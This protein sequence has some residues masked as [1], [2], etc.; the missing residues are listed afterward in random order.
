RRDLAFNVM[1][2]VL[3]WTD[4]LWKYVDDDFHKLYWKAHLFKARNMWLDSY[5]L[6]LEKKREY[7][8]RFYEPRR[9]CFMK[10]GLIQA[11]QDLLDGIYELVAVSL[12][13]GGGKTTLE[14][15]LHSGICGWFPT[16]YNLFYS[17]SGDITRMYYDG[18]YDILTNSEEYTWGEIFPDC[19]VTSTNAKLE[20]ININK[21]KPFPNVQCTSI[22]AKNA[23][24]VRASKF[25]LC[26]DMVGGIEEALN[27]AM[28]ETIWNK[29]S[30]DARQ[31]KIAGCQEL[32]L[33]TRWSC[34][35]PVG[36][37][38]NAYGDNPKY[39]FIAIP[40]IDPETGES[41]FMFD[42]NPFTVEFF[43]D[44]EKIMDEVTYRCLYK[45]DPIEREGLLIPEDKLRRYMQLPQR[46]PDEIIGQCDTKGKGTDYFVLPVLYRYG[47]DYYCEDAICSNDTDYEIQYERSASILVNHKVQS[48]DFER[49]AGGDRVA[50]EVD[51]RVKEKG[52]ICNI[53][54][55]PTETN[56]EAKIFQCSNWIMQHILF[57]DKSQYSNKSDYAELIRELC[58]YSATG[59]NKHDDVPDCL[60]T[61][62]I[63]VTGAAKASVV[64]LTN[65]PFWRR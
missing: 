52:W 19:K 33:M 29:Y 30:V 27:P 5:L 17:H 6:Y 18:M 49:N 60:A 64:T 53:T 22:G 57:K 40:D 21:Y 42:I 55:T 16:E 38:K 65:N 28:L 10:I 23:G 35:D 25:L 20:Q 7:K 34:H 46:E 39:K 1:D 31:R 4:K 15:M 37:L 11:L 47:D 9:K 13:P 2:F 59:K 51:K 3:A 41:N 61:F 43:N 48:C 54:D 32:H 56:K 50:M 44:Q 58:T 12:I 14:K 26:D 45:N 36:R 24:K 63:R 62:A 8:D